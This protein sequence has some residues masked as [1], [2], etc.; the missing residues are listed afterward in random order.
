MKSS[1]KFTDKISLDFIP[2]KS[3][4]KH[5]GTRPTTTP[6]SPPKLQTTPRSLLLLASTISTST[7]VV[8]HGNAANYHRT[9]C[10]WRHLSMDLQLIARYTSPAC[11]SSP[12]N[13]VKTNVYFIRFLTS[14]TL[15]YG[16]ILFHQT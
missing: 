3:I 13:S 8:A 10:M 15:I 7:F 4:S 1:R 2:F 16:L 5:S 14:M 9:G 11:G 12:K 6:H